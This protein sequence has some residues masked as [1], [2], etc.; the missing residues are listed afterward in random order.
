MR[1]DISSGDIDIADVVEVSYTGSDNFYVDVN[2]W[3]IQGLRDD[4]GTDG[5][6]TTQTLAEIR[7]AT[8]DTRAGYLN[9]LITIPPTEADD[10]DDGATALTATADNSIVKP[11]ASDILHLIEIVDH[12]DKTCTD[13]R[14]RLGVMTVDKSDATD[15]KTKALDSSVSV[16]GV[17][18]RGGESFTLA[19]DT[20]G[21][22]AESGTQVNRDT[23]LL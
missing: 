8:G 6:N 23:W 21:S 5:S 22:T 11:N 4:D 20:Q 12:P 7:A 19:S 9:R 16:V 17:S 3:P 1:F 18:Y 15:F 14:I 2:H 10:D 13:C